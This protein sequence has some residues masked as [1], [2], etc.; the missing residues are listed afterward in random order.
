[1]EFPEM[2][3]AMLYV[4]AGKGHYIPAKALA[5]S[6]E[7]GGHES[8]LEDLFVVFDTPFW[9]F[10]CKYDWRFLLHHPRLE[11]VVHSLTD[12]RFNSFLIKMQGFQRKHI[13]AFKAWF[14]RER[15]DFIISTNFIG[16]I[17]LS[18][19]ARKLKLDVPI[20]QYCADVFDTPL[21]GV[22]RDLDRMYLPTE[23]GKENAIRKGQPEETISI[24]PFPL[25]H[26]FETYSYTSRSEVRKKLGLPD[27]FTILCSLGGEG[28]GSTHLLYALAQAGVDCQVVV[29]GGQ[30]SSTTSS[31]ERFESEHPDFPVFLRGFVDNVQEYLAACDI[32]VGKAGANAVMEAI[33]M[34]RPFIVTEVLYAFKAS[35]E[36][37][38]RHEIGW[39]E[40]DTEKQ[41]EIIRRYMSDEDL[42]RRVERSFSDL[43]ISFGSDA[44]RDQ[45]IRD[46]ELYLSSH[47]KA[48]VK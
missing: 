11:P 22:C 40:N 48:A 2:K 46:T 27:R 16:G 47:Q 37:L 44:F 10:F 15:P 26:Q 21:A 32:Q 1:M 9:E 28:I 41:V 24:C 25:R 34:R 33:Y 36:F 30:S 45:L 38:R 35:K 18:S 23:L 6:F 17:I 4:N 12:T 13:N 43:P 31:F 39:G 5:E 7:R 14:E 42:R 29:I 3:G 19:A 8:V 20:Y